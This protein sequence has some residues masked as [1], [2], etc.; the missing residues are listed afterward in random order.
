MQ[1]RIKKLCKAHGIKKTKFEEIQ[2][3]FRVTI[4]KDKSNEGINILYKYIQ[5]N[6]LK[7]V[8]QIK[9]DL[10]IPAKTLERWIKTL[11]DKDKIAFQGSKKTGGYC[12][13]NS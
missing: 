7:R 11:K 13:Q 12:V 8:S 3:G 9:K 2:N 6:P 10:N 4:Y 1:G 5:K